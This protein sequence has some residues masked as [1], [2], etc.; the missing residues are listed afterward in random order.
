[1]LFFKHF[2]YKDIKFLL[3][4]SQNFSK[5]SGFICSEKSSHGQT[6]D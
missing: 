3:F 2:R 1:M 5:K 6:L 4:S